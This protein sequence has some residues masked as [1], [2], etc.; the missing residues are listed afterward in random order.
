MICTIDILTNRT[1]LL[2]IVSEVQVW[3]I[4]GGEICRIVKS[5]RKGFKQL[6]GRFKKDYFTY[7]K[8]QFLFTNHIAVA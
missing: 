5:K 4:E 2:I 1:E 8:P 6:I 7:K 3:L